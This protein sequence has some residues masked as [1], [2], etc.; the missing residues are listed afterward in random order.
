MVQN[1]SGNIE[2]ESDCQC[3]YYFCSACKSVVKEST[4]S[5][6]IKRNTYELQAN[7]EGV[8]ELE[9]AHRSKVR[10]EQAVYFIQGE[11]GVFVIKVLFLAGENTPS[12]VVNRL[13]KKK[14]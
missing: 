1:F 8:F 3:Y 7:E 4:L 14:Y 9:V 11:K 6:R 5:G 12:A 13:W 10:D 2:Y